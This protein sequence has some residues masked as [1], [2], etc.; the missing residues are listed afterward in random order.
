MQIGIQKRSIRDLEIGIAYLAIMATG[1]VLITFIPKALN[2]IP[3]CLFRLWT[4]IPCPACGGT[5]CAVYLVHFEIYNAL[6]ANP[7]I[8]L[9]LL[10]LFLWGVNT[11]VGIVL[12]KNLKFQLSHIEKRIMNIILLFA[13]PLNWI[14]L[15]GKTFF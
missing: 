15:I 9:S 13:V 8:F 5:H 2:L 14:Y 7:F 3:P 12:G 1:F 11:I 6:I 4:G 10:L